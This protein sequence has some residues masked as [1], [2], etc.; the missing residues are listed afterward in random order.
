MRLNVAP[1][2][3]NGNI[4][5]YCGFTTNSHFVRVSKKSDNTAPYIGMREKVKHF[6]HSFSPPSHEKTI[7]ELSIKA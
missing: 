7:L 4:I 2:K 6:S 3:I 5:L 1:E